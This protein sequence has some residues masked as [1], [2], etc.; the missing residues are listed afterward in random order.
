MWLHSWSV[1]IKK[2][3][4]CHIAIFFGCFVYGFSLSHVCHCALVVFC[5]NK[6]WCSSVP[7]LFISLLVEM[8]FV[9]FSDTDFKAYRM[10]M[11]SFYCSCL[12]A[13]LR[14]AL[15]G[16]EMWAALVLFRLQLCYFFLSQSVKFSH[17]SP[18]V[19][20]RL[21]HPQSSLGLSGIFLS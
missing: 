19:C 10:V 21:P 3:S 17:K 2:A 15:L 9:C 6:G 20:W 1:L 18:L 4:P 8:V 12:C 13:V 5:V 11:S 7:L 14:M 16:L